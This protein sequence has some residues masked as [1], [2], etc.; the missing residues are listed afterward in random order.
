MSSFKTIVVPYDFT[1]QSNAA[2]DVADGLAQQFGAELHLLHVLQPPPYAYAQE[3]GAG[4]S[5]REGGSSELHSPRSEDC[6]HKLDRVATSCWGS[7]RSLLKMMNGE[8]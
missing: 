7:H 5:G 6:M 3:L 8:D 1:D 2:L 4:S